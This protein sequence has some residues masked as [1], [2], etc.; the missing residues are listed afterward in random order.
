MEWIKSRRK[1]FYCI[2]FLMSPSILID[3]NLH[4]EVREGVVIESTKVDFSFSFKREET[5]A[6]KTF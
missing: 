5:G 4:K 1:I 3:V 2:A 6:K